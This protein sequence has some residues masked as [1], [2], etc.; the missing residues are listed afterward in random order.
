MMCSVD[1]IHIVHIFQ[2]VST[3]MTVNMSVISIDQLLSNEI[4][5]E[6]FIDTATKIS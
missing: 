6:G 1:S 2:C 4:A 5:L 3:I